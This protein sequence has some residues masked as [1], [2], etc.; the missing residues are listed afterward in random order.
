V[1]RLRRDELHFEIEVSAVHA[2]SQLQAMRQE[3]DTSPSAMRRLL[4]ALASDAGLA[5]VCNLRVRACVRLRLP[6][7]VTP[8]LAQARRVRPLSS[9]MVRERE[10][11]LREPLAVPDACEIWI[12]PD[13]RQAAFE[14]IDLAAAAEIA[15]AFRLH[16]L[17][18]LAEIAGIEPR[19]GLASPAVVELAL[20]CNLS[21]L[22]AQLELDGLLR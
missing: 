3:A 4:S 13:Y 11:L 6:D 1:I 12:T 10:R 16:L 17:A 5:D 15:P 9:R 20:P 21:A 8:L 22:H 19:D 2:N 18:T 7:R 14:V